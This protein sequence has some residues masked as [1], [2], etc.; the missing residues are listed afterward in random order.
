MDTKVELLEKYGNAFRDLINSKIWS[1]KGDIR[2]TL[3]L[4]K[5]GDWA[6][7]CISMD[8]LEDACTAIN[9]FLKFG[10]NGPTKYDDVG[11]KYLR[12]YGILSATYIQQ[13]ALVKVYQLM[14][15]GPSLKEGKELVDSL[16][17][18]S[19]RHKL[20]SHSTN[21]HD[22]ETDSIQAYVPIRCD[23]DN[24]NC[25]YGKNGRGNH[26]SVDLKAA[27]DE[28]LNMMIELLDKIME[29]A[30]KTLFKGQE[31]SKSCIEFSKVLDDL[32]VLRK[33][34]LVYQLP[35]GRKLIVTMTNEI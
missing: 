24:F 11:E 27:V 18:R 19:L 9:S 7:L 10:L 32:R 16:L 25:T 8:I 5:D 30:I 4:S 14:N 31:S 1:S 23:L 3:R 26:N 2:E 22:K 6:F 28:H 29:K 33:G 21:Y 12:L 35:D 13:E 20:S 34:G 17:I 15:V